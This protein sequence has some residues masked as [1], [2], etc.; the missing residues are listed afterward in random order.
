MAVTKLALLTDDDDDGRHV[1]AIAHQRWAKNQDIWFDFHFCIL[2]GV[3]KKH[4]SITNK[5]YRIR[6]FWQIMIYLIRKWFILI[7]SWTART[8]VLPVCIDIVFRILHALSAFFSFWM[9]TWF[10]WRIASNILWVVTSDIFCRVDQ[11]GHLS[12]P[13]SSVWIMEWILDL[14]KV[15]CR[16]FHIKIHGQA[17]LF[18]CLV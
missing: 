6:V 15:G 1:I 3:G 4:L 9:P 16:A 5:S 2:Q 10:E 11:I 14:G 13:S 18:L 17:R 8:T 12:P 7:L